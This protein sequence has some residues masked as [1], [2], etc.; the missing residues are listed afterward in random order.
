MGTMSE[1]TRSFIEVFKPRTGRYSLWDE[2]AVPDERG[3]KWRWQRTKLTEEIIEEAQQGRKLISFLCWSSTQYF[4]V[5]VDDHVNGGWL[6]DEPTNELIRKTE[7]AFRR[8][9]T[10]PCAIF[11]S[12]HGIHAFWFFDKVLPML[13]IQDIIEARLGK[14]FEFLPQYTTGIQDADPCGLY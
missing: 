13:V 11:R 10:K 8:V 7:E 3:R 12:P 4:G 9:G 5:D 14:A 1:A 2:A 6:G